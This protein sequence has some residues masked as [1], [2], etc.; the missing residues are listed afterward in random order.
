M[1][2]LFVA[3]DLSAKIDVSCETVK[4]GAAERWLAGDRSLFPSPSSPQV[5]LE[6]QAAGEGRWAITLSSYFWL[7]NK[8]SDPGLLPVQNLAW[9]WRVRKINVQLKPVYG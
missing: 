6:E 4:C 7:R 3:A 2:R 8:Q 5:I 9:E 1:G